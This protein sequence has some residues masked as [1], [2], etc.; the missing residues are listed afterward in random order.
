[1]VQIQEAGTFKRD[2]KRGAKGQHGKTLIYRK[3]DAENLEL[4]RLG[5]HSELRL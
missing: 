2:I 3:Q 4:L 5:S 1:M